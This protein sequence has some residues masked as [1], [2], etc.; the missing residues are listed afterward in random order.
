MIVTPTLTRCD[1][2]DAPMA[3]MPGPMNHMKRPPPPEGRQLGYI[4]EL[5]DRIHT[6]CASCLH[7]V[8]TTAA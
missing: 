5:A 6:I 4:V 1:L 7:T 2:C 3:A 8:L